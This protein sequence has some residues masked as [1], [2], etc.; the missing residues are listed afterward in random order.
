MRIQFLITS[1]RLND[2]FKFP[3]YKRIRNISHVMLTLVNKALLVK[4][5]YLSQECRSKLDDGFGH[6]KERREEKLQ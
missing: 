3:R 2:Y 6:R 1:A 5:F 4:G